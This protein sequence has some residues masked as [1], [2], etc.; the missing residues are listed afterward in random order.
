MKVGVM[1]GT[2]TR[3]YSDCELNAGSV[4]AISILP[5]LM[6]PHQQNQKVPVSL[7]IAPPHSSTPTFHW[8]MKVK[9]SF[10]KYIPILK[11]IF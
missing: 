5:F 8:P 1:G 3:K 9:L 6:Q 11:A 4:C 10:E 7:E 2:M